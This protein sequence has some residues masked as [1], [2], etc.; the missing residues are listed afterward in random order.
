MFFLFFLENTTIVYSSCLTD[1]TWSVVSLTCMFNPDA[2]PKHVD[3]GHS[4]NSGDNNPMNIST[5]ITIGILSALIVLSLIIVIII[6]S[7]RKTAEEESTRKIS[8]S[9]TNQLIY[10]QVGPKADEDYSVNILDDAP[11]AADE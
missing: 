11:A 4:Y 1:G 5:I 6:I 7:H 10:D 9:S 3:T 2:R 8:Q